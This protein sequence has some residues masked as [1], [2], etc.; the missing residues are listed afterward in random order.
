MKVK[1]TKRKNIFSIFPLENVNPDYN[2]AQSR[3]KISNK[4]ARVPRFF[5]LLN[6]KNVNIFYKVLFLE[7]TIAI[8]PS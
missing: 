8:L 6:Q 5:S 1:K 4:P 7:L 3:E 2:Y